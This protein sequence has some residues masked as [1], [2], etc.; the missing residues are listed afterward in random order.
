MLRLSALEP[1]ALGP[2]VPVPAG[3]AG[4]A[5]PAAGH[6]LHVLGPVAPAPSVSSVPVRLVRQRSLL[7]MREAYL[8][9]VGRVERW[10]LQGFLAKWNYTLK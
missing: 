9:T 1:S 3:P 5:G 4:P 6:M 8:G 10:R 7:P 2:F